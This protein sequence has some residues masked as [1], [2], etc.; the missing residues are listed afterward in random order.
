MST[1]GSA[2]S[3]DPTVVALEQDVHSSDE[4]VTLESLSKQLRNLAAH[5]L[6]L[7][8]RVRE[9]SNHVLKL[10][11]TIDPL[12]W[13]R[14]AALIFAGA[15]AGGGMAFLLLHTAIALASQR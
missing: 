1:N 15:V 14:R 2:H 3:T 5:H 13:K 4:P 12:T 10:H 6:T 11:Q 9:N 8:R 7:D